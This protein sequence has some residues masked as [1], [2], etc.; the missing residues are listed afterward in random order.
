MTLN[1]LALSRDARLSIS[2]FGL[3]GLV[4]FGVEPLRLFPG[5]KI[6]GIKMQLLTQGILNLEYLRIGGQDD[7]IP[8]VTACRSSSKHP[9]SGD[10]IDLL[11]GKPIHTTNELLPFWEVNFGR[12][13]HIEELQ[14]GNRIGR[15]CERAYGLV[16][17]IT[18]EQGIRWTFDNLGA[19]QFDARL[20][21][22][23]ANV[24]NFTS[25]CYKLP[26]DVRLGS[27]DA[28][29]TFTGCARRHVDLVRAALAGGSASALELANS[30]ISLLDSIS[31]VLESLQ[32]KHLVSAAKSVFPVLDGLIPRGNGAEIGV[33]VES[34]LSALAW[35]YISLLT[36]SASVRLPHVNDHERTLSDSS[37]TRYVEREVNR[38]Y[39]AT[40]LSRT[41]MPVLFRAHGM[42]GSPLQ[43]DPMSFINSM[44]DIED[45]FS[46][47]GYDVAISYGTLLGAVREKTF[48]EHDD[49]VDMIV[50]LKGAGEQKFLDEM[51]GLLKALNER[52]VEAS[53]AS[54]F[55]FLKV[56]SPRFKR[57]VDVFPVIDRSD[58][59]VGMYMQSLSIR[60]VP[61]E[62]V[63][64]FG[65]IEFYG[66][67]FRAPSAP[68]EFLRERYGD[69]WQVPL[70]TIGARSMAV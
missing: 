69:T 24:Q 62:V 22:Y 67:V 23:V 11:K 9:S 55:S 25:L 42:A 64:P 30:R 15:W 31:A 10:P 59:H 6:A 28:L 16:L 43:S 68:E 48:I 40:G 46:Q 17:D 33:N 45:I 39:E 51:K 44:K 2:T 34:E 66:R 57:M 26:R 13:V 18:D 58:G 1:M 29:L 19:S 36:E 61:R 7:I 21:R 20:D 60:D 50:R 65:D 70:R 54:G 63:L 32:G 8:A 35:I 38:R 47:I 27:A 49:D 14:I 53:F 56:K 12:A 4:H 5:R 41:P 37:C 3:P 52:G